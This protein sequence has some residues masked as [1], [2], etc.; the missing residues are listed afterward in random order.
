MKS[1]S[2]VLLAGAFA[3][4]T[5]AAFAQSS[6]GNATMNPPAAK[7]APTTSQGDPKMKQ[8]TGETKA[9]VK[10]KADTKA[11][12]KT[13]AT[14]GAGDPS[15]NKNMSGTSFGQGSSDPAAKGNSGIKPGTKTE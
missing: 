6:S 4:A 10:I 7:T 13:N 8:T 5:T 2:T 11:K 12:T 3:L 14:T 9:D 1:I 15:P